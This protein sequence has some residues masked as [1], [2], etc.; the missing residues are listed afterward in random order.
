LTQIDDLFKTAK[1]SLASLAA[2]L[3]VGI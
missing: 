1:G 3:M 2:L